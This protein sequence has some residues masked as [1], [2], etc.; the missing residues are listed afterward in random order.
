MPLSKQQVEQRL[1]SL[2]GWERDDDEIQREFKF[3][4]FTDAIAFVNRIAEQAEEMDHH[5]DIE[6]K[7]NRVKLELSTHSEGGVTDRDFELARRIDAAA[8]G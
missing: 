6:I 2:P 5:P 1:A 7:Y 8:A 3:Q 4:G